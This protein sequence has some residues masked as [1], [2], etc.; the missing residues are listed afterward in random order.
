MRGMSRICIAVALTTLCYGCGHT[1]V[2]RVGLLS[3]GDLEWR[4]IPSTV[5]GPVLIEK[6]A[7]K[8]RVVIRTSCPRLYEMYSPERSTTHS[9]MLK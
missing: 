3:V 5:D 1:N 6:D 9:W 4:T 8:R 2:S 7:C